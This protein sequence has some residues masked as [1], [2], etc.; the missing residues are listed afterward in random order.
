MGTTW[1]LFKRETKAYFNSPMA[2]VFLFIFLLVSGI[3]FFD[4]G[5][6]LASGL[7][8]M[9]MFFFF[10]PWA[11]LIFVPA[12]AMRL[13]AEERKLGTAELLMTLPVRDVEAVLGKYLASLLILTLA[14]VLTFPIP[15]IVGH[16]ADP[17]VGVDWGPIVSGYVGM[18]LMGAAYLSIGMFI[19]ALTSN[20]ILAFIGGV[21]VSFALFLVGLP[22]VLQRLPSWLVPLFSY[23]GFSSHM[24]N[25]SRGVLDSRDVV[26]FLSIIVLFVFLTV[27]AV[28]GRK[29]R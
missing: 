19:S 7:A 3:M 9:R 11:L 29:W 17:Q 4:I 25:I 12:I 2:Y 26:Y 6:F 8:D 20:Q 27:R 21:V 23:L 14:L 1:T 28:E 18:F 24:M 22:V 15:W 13:W 5:N 10:V 16:L